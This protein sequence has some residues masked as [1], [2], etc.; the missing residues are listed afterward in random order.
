[1]PR[2]LIASLF[3]SAL[4]AVSAEAQALAVVP[5][6]AFV[7]VSVIPMDRDRVLTRQTVVVRGD[8]IVAL[9]PVGQVAVPSDAERVDGAGKFLMPG[10]ADM[11]VHFGNF[12]PAPMDGP[13]RFTL[14]PTVDVADMLFTFVANGVTT[15]RDMHSGPDAQGNAWLLA[16]RRRVGAGKLL[17]PRIYTAG[18]PDES[19]PAAAAKSVEALKAA[20]Y[21]FVK[22]YG[23]PRPLYDSV[24]A[25]ARRVGLPVAGHVPG[26]D[27]GIAGVLRDR[28]ASIEHLTGYFEY[29]TGVSPESTARKRVDD[30]TL[31]RIARETERAGVWN[32]P[33]PSIQMTWMGMDS[34]HFDFYPR[35]IKALHDAGAGLLLGTDAYFFDGTLAHSGFTI[36]AALE[37]LV[38]AGLTPYQALETGTRNVARFLRTEDSTGTVA[39]GKR[40]DLV[41]LNANPLVD[42]HHTT[43]LAGVMLGGRWLPRVDLNRWIDTMRSVATPNSGARGTTAQQLRL[44]SEIVWRWSR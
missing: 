38:D 32:C 22:L 21:D 23:R 8:H 28:W 11:H 9:G 1:M 15:V 39:V 17:G 12:D 6:T 10:L 42:V 18:D 20:G 4:A 44:L 41:L 29:A 13:P 16:V 37:A 25:A 24:V 43:A 27:I 40:A 3:V 14:N 19:S 30:A 26:E 31:R 34:V 33:A 36:H 7:N 35:L 5:V 2:F